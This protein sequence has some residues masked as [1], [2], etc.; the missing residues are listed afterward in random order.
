MVPDHPKTSLF[1][2]YVLDWGSSECGLVAHQDR[3]QDSYVRLGAS[4]ETVN[5]ELLKVG[6]TSE[7]A[8]PSQA[9]KDEGVETRRAASNGRDFLR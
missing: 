4:L 8:I 9:S 5:V 2:I 7:M 6:E 1:V 3:A